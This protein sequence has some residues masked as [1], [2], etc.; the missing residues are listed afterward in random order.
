MIEQE[1]KYTLTIVHR[2]KKEK[3]NNKGKRQKKK[4]END[5]IIEGCEGYIEKLRGE[6]KIKLKRG[7]TKKREIIIYL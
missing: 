7:E 4:R 6:E 2:E 5:D 3:K 1:E